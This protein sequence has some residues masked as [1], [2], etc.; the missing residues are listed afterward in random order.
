MRRLAV[1]G[2]CLLG[3]AFCLAACGGHEPSTTPSQGDRSQGPQRETGEQSVERFGAEAGGSGKQAILSAERGYLMAL[4]ERD[5]E[6]ACHLLAS[7]VQRS[8]RR[9]VVKPLK[10]QGCPAI[11]PKAL[12]QSAPAIA[13]R[14]AN[15]E[16]TKVRVEGEQ[17]FVIFRAPG[18]KLYVFTLQEEGGDWRASALSASILVPDPAT[19]G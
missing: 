18:A 7:Q 19:F 5:Y 6:A 3:S 16:I 2:L 17:A 1:L 15:G 8:L 13:R 14:Q 10:A 9:L 11:L 12:S 4:A